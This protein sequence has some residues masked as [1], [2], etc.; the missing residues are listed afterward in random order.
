MPEGG[1]YETPAAPLLP[2]PQPTNWWP[3]WD[4]NPQLGFPKTGLSRPRMPASPL[5]PSVESEQ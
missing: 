4:L 1:A 5:G 2:A 3:R